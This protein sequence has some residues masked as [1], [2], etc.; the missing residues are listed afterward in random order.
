MG[1]VRWLGHSSFEVQV[2]GKRILIDPWLTNPQ[3]VAKPEDFA[4]VDYVI[5]THDHGDHLGEAVEVMRKS[6]ARFVGIYELATWVAEQGIGQDRVVGGNIGGPMKL[7]GIEVM[8]TPA[9]HS[10]SRGYPAGALILSDEA[11]IYHAG[12]TGLSAEMALLGELYRIHVALIP[13]GGHFTMDP[14]QAAKAVEMLKPRTVVP[15]HYGTFPV[16]Y[17]EPEDFKRLVEEK[18]LDT[19]VVILRPGEKLEF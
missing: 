15:M 6:R 9:T 16:L 18:G 4:D 14:L 2:S 12:D 11:N 3:G 13:I 5:V 10:A 19:R 7:D 17:G 8:L 1:Y